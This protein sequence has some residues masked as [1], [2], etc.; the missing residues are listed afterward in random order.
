MGLCAVGLLGLPPALEAQTGFDT[1]NISAILED[2][3][4]RDSFTRYSSVL[5]FF[6]PEEATR[7][8]FTSGNNLL[9]D[10]TAQNDERSRNL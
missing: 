8:G 7:L 1:G 2:N 10:R 4:L 3:S 6:F 9:N 5:T